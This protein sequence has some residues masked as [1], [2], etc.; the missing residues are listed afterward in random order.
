MSFALNGTHIEGGTFNNV[1]GNMSQVFNSHVVHVGASASRRLVEGPRDSLL[2]TGRSIAAVRFQGVARHEGD[3][4]YDHTDPGHRNSQRQLL[5]TNHD[6]HSSDDRLAILS[7][8]VPTSL[9]DHRN[10]SAESFGPEPRDPA[11]AG[12]PQL[13]RFEGPTGENNPA[14][15]STNTFT[16]VAGNMTHF[17]VTSYGE[18]GLDILYRYVVMEALHDS[19]ERFPEPACH[20]GTRTALLSEL[21]SWS[22][23]SS[24]TSTI[25]WLYG[26][27]GAGKSA[28]AQ[29]FATECQAQGRLGGSFFF[30]RGHPK[31]GTWHGLC[32]TLAYKL[33]VSVSQL[34]LPVQQ[35]VESDKLVLGRAL[36]GQ[37][38]KL[39][40]EPFQHASDLQTIPV[41]VVD[42]LDECEDRNVQQEIL[43]LFVQAIHLHQLPIRLLIASRPEPHIREIL[44][45]D[46]TS[47]ICRRTALGADV[48]AYQDIRTYLRDEFSRVNSKYMARGVDLGP[49][50]SQNSLELLVKKSS[51]I[52]I[53]AATI[54]R[55]VDDEY[56]HPADRLAAVL[57]L[58]PRSTAPLDDL[59]SQILSVVPQEPQQL[60]ILHAIWR[61]TLT[62][63]ARMDPEEIDMF[64]GLRPGTCRLLLRG[65]HSLFNVPPRRT[66]FGPRKLISFLHAS[67]AD[68]LRDIKRSA[69]WCVSA[70]WLYTDYLHS[71]IRLLS[72][73]LLIDSAWNL[74]AHII[75]TLRGLLR[76]T[77]PGDTLIGL[78]RNQIFQENIFLQAVN[79]HDRWRKVYLVSDLLYLTQPLRS[80]QLSVPLG[81]NP[82]MGRSPTHFKDC[83]PSIQVCGRK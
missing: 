69:G 24:P 76:V 3:R 73:P 82:A 43:R 25:L 16:S 65:L 18:S 42:G 13:L 23:D 64:S 72:S 59:Y 44:E 80:A 54:V 6:N 47:S 35:A 27:A 5:H 41:I 58:D 81:F 15:P 2:S 26:S 21:N 32:S 33:T 66:R 74:Y 1:A 78:L 53:Y 9:G 52:F 36:T 45:S 83:R 40:V 22:L 79:T 57:S 7:Q 29:M 20:P 38:K 49:W 71:A 8:H 51:G 37:F 77:N 28:I 30:K 60:R 19:G 56:S 48:S 46:A 68:Y 10:I 34:L 61:Q 70:P 4:P 11:H 50:P 62:G 67:L 63:G 39:L 14:D 12:I 55:F 31:R 75:V 17:N